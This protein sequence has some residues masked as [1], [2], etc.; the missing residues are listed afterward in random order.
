MAGEHI[1]II[2]DDRRSFDSLEIIFN[3]YRLS[4][5][6][7][8]MT[9]LKILREQNHVD[10]ILLDIMMP[11]IDG[12]ET[13]RQ[14]KSI[15][16]AIGV[17]MMTALGSKDVILEALQGHADDFIEKPFSPQDIRSKVQKVLEETCFENTYDTR[18]RLKM[19]Q[20]KQYLDLNC[21]RRVSLKELAEKVNMS[22][23]YLSRAFRHEMGQTLGSYQCQS[24]MNEARKLLRTQDE[25][26][27]LIAEKKGYRNPTTFMTM[28]KKT[29]GISPS[30][31]RAQSRQNS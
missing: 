15:N 12:L 17:I 21:H 9:G 31:Y 25:P 22:E 7:D 1:L 23:K 11:G 10:L 6:S 5:A 14:I 8:G 19:R 27:H 29:L 20:V 18:R 13:L 28:F 4:Y 26:V 30:T 2:D 16:R 3:E 24:R